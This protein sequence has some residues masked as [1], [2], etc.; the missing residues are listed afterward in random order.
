MDKPSPAYLGDDDYV[1]VSY[2][3]SNASTVYGELIRLQSE[4]INIWYDEGISP[5]S[6]WTQEI[7][8]AIERCKVFVAFVSID[9]ISSENCVN[10][11]EFAVSKGKRIVQVY[12][13]PTTLPSG[14]ELS[15]SGRQALL[16]YSLAASTYETQLVN[17]LM[18]YLQDTPAGVQPRI[19]EQSVPRR[20]TNVL[21]GIVVVALLASAIFVINRDRESTVDYPDRRPAIAVLPFENLT[22]SDENKYFAEGL[23]DD[24]IVRLGAWR[25]LPVV[26]R[27]SSFDPSL[28]N[29]AQEI[30]DKLDAPRPGEYGRLS[31]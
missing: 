1:F 21:A 4:G 15:F 14:L 23:A 29:N 30:G 22:E 9:F 7:A 10:E 2:A 13:E 6:R 28:G 18:E 27:A 16:K 3:H 8:D 24:L 5:G 12:L 26:A 20:K 11:A 19:P 17:L 31:G 25:S